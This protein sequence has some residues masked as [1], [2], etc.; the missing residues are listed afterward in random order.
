MTESSAL[1]LRNDAALT[2]EMTARAVALRDA[3]LEKTAGIGVIKT[4]VH[5]ANAAEIHKEI[6]NFKRDVETARCAAKEQIIDY[7]RRIDQAAKDLL[8][9]VL[10][11]ESR[12]TAEL[13][14]YHTVEL[15][16][17]RAEEAKER[18]EQA[19]IEKR[20]QEQ[21]AL[22]ATHDERDKVNARADEEAKL[23]KPAVVAVPPKGQKVEE[24]WEYTINNPIVLACEHPELIRRVEFNDQKIRA[25]LDI[26]GKLPCVEARKVVAVGTRAERTVR[27]EALQV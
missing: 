6:A 23:A 2:A 12:I 17:K 11:E 13:G 14:N 19:E 8:A 21:L 27:K 3:L 4:P 24:I 15:A 1:I 20:R 22:A 25:A 9:P 16:R 10:D 18:K 7:G 26:L 5:N